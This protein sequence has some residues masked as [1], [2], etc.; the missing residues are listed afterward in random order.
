MLEH[1]VC[2]L[3]RPADVAEC[4][5]A[6]APEVILHLAAQPIVGRALLDPAETFGVN[7]MGTVHL[8]EAARTAETVRAIV[9][10]TSDKV[11]RNSEW[12]WPYRETDRLG[13]H[14]PYGVSKACCELVVEAYRQSLFGARPHPPALATVRAG[15]IIGGGDWG[16]SR[17]VPDAIRAF[18]GGEPLV[19]R[20]PGSI[21]PW[22]HVADVVRGY[23]RLAETLLT[24]PERGSGAWNLGPLESDAWTVARLADRLVDAWGTPARWVADGPSLGRESGRLRV[25]S[26]RAVTHLGWRPHFSTEAAIDAAVAW[27]RAHGRGEPVAG[28][29][30]SHLHQAGCL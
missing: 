12:D 11:Y 14:E 13:G 8:L 18:A 26:S 21:R 24:D 17:L 5:R 2:D 29:T 15:N 25:D 7:V 30:I 1:R 20:H 23:L 22:Q 4:V 10:V 9:V 16:E 27:Y 28:L 19:L 6:A 3:R